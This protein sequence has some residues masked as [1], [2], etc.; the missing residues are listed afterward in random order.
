MSVIDAVQRWR[1]ACVRWFFAHFFMLLFLAVTLG[2]WGTLQWVI[3]PRT[4]PLPWWVHGTAII[5]VYALNHRIAGA[6]RRQR[7]SPHPLGTGPQLYYA[8]AF[9][10][11]F[12]AAFLLVNGVLWSVSTLLL[13]AV[14]V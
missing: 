13:G 7:I 14:A 12:C 2:Q 1:D 4:G 5:G 9:T 6:L 3:R 11:L 8:F 10:S